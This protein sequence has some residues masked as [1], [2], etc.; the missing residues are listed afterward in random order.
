MASM[1]QVRG[2]GW[3]VVAWA[4]RWGVGGRGRRVGR[5]AAKHVGLRALAVRGRARRGRAGGRHAAQEAGLRGAEQRLSESAG[6]PRQLCSMP[7]TYKLH[8]G[9]PSM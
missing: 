8:A 9:Q 4:C 1:R 2:K 3:K 6:L 7:A 5:V